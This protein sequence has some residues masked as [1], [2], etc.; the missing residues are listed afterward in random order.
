MVA[1]IHGNRKSL[2]EEQECRVDNLTPSQRL[3][4]VTKTNNLPARI[5]RAFDFGY[6]GNPV[7]KPEGD[8]FS[9]PAS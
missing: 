2:V 1:E 4:L 6:L 8:L 3:E 7:P 9:K 5:A